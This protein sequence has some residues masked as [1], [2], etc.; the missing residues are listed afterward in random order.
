VMGNNPSH[1]K[2][3]GDDCP[4]EHLSWNDVQ[5]FIHKLNQREGSNTYRL[6]TEAEWEYA[7]RAGTKTPFSFGRCLSTDQ[8]NYNGNYPLSGCVKGKY[9]KRTIAVASFQPNSWGLYDMHGN[10]WEWCQDWYGDY[11]SVSW[12]V[13][14]P[15]GG[16][17]GDKDDRV[18]YRGRVT[19]GGSSDSYARHCRSAFRHR[20]EPNSYSAHM[21]FRL[22]RNP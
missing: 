18:F 15:T 16:P 3:C 20:L 8:S 5:P 4:V 6:P 12:S 10:V 17:P 1:F 11:P 2:N 14:N 19:R 22:V 7:A 13:T 21:G 9:R